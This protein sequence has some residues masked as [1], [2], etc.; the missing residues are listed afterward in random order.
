MRNSQKRYYKHIK[1]W[2]NK[3]GFERLLTIALLLIVLFIVSKELKLLKTDQY[4]A[5]IIKEGIDYEAFRDIKIDE[6]ILLESEKR[7][8]IILEKYPYLQGYTYVDQIGYLTCIMLAQ[9][10]NLGEKD[11]LHEYVFIRGLDDLVQTE[12]FR[13]L[14]EYYGAI[15]NDLQYFPVAVSDT[16]KPGFS[17]EDS[18]LVMRSYGGKRR[19]EGT[20]IMALDNKRGVLPIVSIT[21][22]V[23]EK[24]GWLEKGGYRIGIRSPSGGYFYYAHLD[25]Y[26]PNLKE[27]QSVIAGQILGFM[28]DSGYGEEGTIGKFDVHL[29]LGIYVSSKIGEMSVNPY[30]ILK[31]LERNQIFYLGND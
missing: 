2:I 24:M 1:G 17:Y 18:W 12:A 27:G 23:I 25:D 21:D 10:Y 16:K 4:I 30:Y 3:P 26:A 22:G 5:K 14:Y 31:M 8:G 7:I 19:H 20:D 11:N 28:G 29:H 9:N 13:E 15:I 6:S